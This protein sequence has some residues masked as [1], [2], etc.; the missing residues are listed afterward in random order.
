MSGW[1]SESDLRYLIPN[2]SSLNDERSTL[3]LFLGLGLLVPSD[4]VW[5]RKHDWQI[6][7]AWSFMLVTLPG[8]RIP[9]HTVSNSAEVAEK[10]AGNSL[11][12][13]ANA[14]ETLDIPWHPQPQLGKSWRYRIWFLREE[15]PG[16]CLLRF[17]PE[18]ENK[19]CVKCCQTWRSEI[20]TG[21]GVLRE[22]P[23]FC[24]RHHAPS[25]PCPHPCP[26]HQ[27]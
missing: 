14:S 15:A 27:P 19:S 6:G 16:P 26:P 23:A 25:S 24:H 3:S 7:K 21:Y 12:L 20:E 10:M 2:G 5:V 8:V 11:D 17:L 9:Y 18:L 13:K 1:V 22:M 4:G